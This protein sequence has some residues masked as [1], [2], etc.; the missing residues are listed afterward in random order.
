M[1][2]AAGREWACVKLSAGASA[3]TVKAPAAPDGVYFMVLEAGGVRETK[4][5]SLTH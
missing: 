5:F 3:C 2:S 4:M 1:V